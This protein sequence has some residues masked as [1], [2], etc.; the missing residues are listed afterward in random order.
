M[1]NYVWLIIFLPLFLV[2]WE[3][4]IRGQREKQKKILHFIKQKR[5]GGR[6]IMSESIS[7][8]IGKDCII[9]TMNATITGV[10]ESVD[11]NWLNIRRA[12]KG[13]EA[14]IVNVDYVSQIREYPRNKNGKKKLIAG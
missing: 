5:L 1:D 4:Y 9:T 12:S 7:K 10:L 3:E 8:F 14:E 13:S 2:L 6:I 11:G